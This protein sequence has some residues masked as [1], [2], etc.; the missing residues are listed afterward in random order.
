MVNFAIIGT[1]SISEKFIGALK[2]SGKCNFYALLSRNELK[3]KEFAKKH[4][5]EKVYTDINEM[6]KDEKIVGN[7]EN[8][9][10][11]IEEN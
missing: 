4:G 9:E 2:N 11:N 3:G 5:I 10:E 1:S 8:S 6:L 7:F